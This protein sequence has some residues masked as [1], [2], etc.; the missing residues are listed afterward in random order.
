M[1]LSDAVQVMPGARKKPAEAVNESWFVQFCCSDRVRSSCAILFAGLL[2]TSAAYAEQDFYGIQMKNEDWARNLMLGKGPQADPDDLLSGPIL[3]HA[4]HGEAFLKPVGNGRLDFGV[5]VFNGSDLPIPA[6]YD[7][8]DFFFYTKDGKKYPLLDT[9]EDSALSIEPHSKAVFAPSLGNLRVKNSD[10][11][12]IQCSFDLGDTRLFL[13]PWSQK[14]R[15]SK[16]VSPPAPSA[17][18]KPAKKKAD[19]GP[20]KKTPKRNF[21]DWIAPHQRSRQLKKKEP[22]KPTA[23]EK[24]AAS[25]ARVP[26]PVPSQEKLDSAIKNFVYVPAGGAASA[27]AP[28][29]APAP[30]RDEARVLDFNKDY[31]FITLNLGKN[32]GLQDN[33]LVSIVREGKL[34]AKAKVKQARAAVAAAAVLPDTVRGEIRAGDKI[35][36]A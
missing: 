26:Q 16:L 33:M 4:V 6:D 23:V 13:F 12:M 31:N 27:V 8:R 10:V 11:E 15:V 17:P 25:P 22:V 3:S 35:A 1:N 5:T 9:D 14:D 7:L 19:P 29:S 21:W 20:K 18:A 24:S 30:A 2:L 28:S 34:V 32:D 36:F